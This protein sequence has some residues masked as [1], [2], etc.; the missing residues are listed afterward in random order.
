MK[1]ERRGRVART[2][3][4][5]AQRRSVQAVS[6]ENLPRRVQNQLALEVA[7]SLLPADF[8]LFRHRDS[9]IAHLTDNL[10]TVRL[11][12]TV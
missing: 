8:P 7:Y 6:V 1:I 5:R 10:N 12:N 9:Q 4:D 11:F 2:G 3:G